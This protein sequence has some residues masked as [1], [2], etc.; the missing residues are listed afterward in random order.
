MAT[1]HGQDNHGFTEVF[2]FVDNLRPM[3]GLSD[4]IRMQNSCQLLLERYQRQWLAFKAAHGLGR[5][6]AK[7]RSEEV[8]PTIMLASQQRKQGLANQK[9]QGKGPCRAMEQVESTNHELLALREIMRI[10]GKLI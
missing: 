1:A 3:T 4:R 8:V 5:I 7:P 2:G 6:G 10:A 9:Q